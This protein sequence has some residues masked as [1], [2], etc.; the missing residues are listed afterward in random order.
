MG[1]DRLKIQLWTLKWEWW[2]KTV[3]ETWLC[4]HTRGVQ[5]TD[6]SCLPQL[7]STVI[8]R[9]TLPLHLKLTNV[10]W[11]SSKPQKSACPLHCLQPWDY[12]HR[13]LLGNPSRS[14]RFQSDCSTTW[15]IVPTSLSWAFKLSNP[16]SGESKGAS[17]MTASN[18]TEQKLTFCSVSHI[19]D[20]MWETRIVLNKTF[21]SFLSPYFP[22]Q[23]SI[24]LWK[25]AFGWNSE[26]G[27]KKF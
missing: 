25:E 12:R 8:L 19:Q 1:S 11:P 22:L 20:K 14:S 3:P 5:S 10:N 23:W 6:G 17:P 24:F 7:C 2:R 9:Q 13:L 18:C 16:K 26:G 15:G 27:V 21:A 4:V